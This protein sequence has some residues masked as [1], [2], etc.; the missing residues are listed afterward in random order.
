MKVTWVKCEG[1]TWCSFSRVD[2]SNVR[3]SGVY[4]IWKPGTDGTVIRVGQGDIAERIADH[5]RD[6]E[7]TSYGSDLLV[8]WASVASQYLD[9]VERF[10]ADKYSPLVGDR[11]PIATPIAVN[12]PGK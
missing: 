7:I 9:G 10:L 12:L 6:S 11:F 3:T 1:D 2:L 5:R 8:T 4:V